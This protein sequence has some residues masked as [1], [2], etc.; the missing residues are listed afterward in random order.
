MF[1]KKSFVAALALLVV[2]ALLLIALDADANCSYWYS[3]MKYYYSSFLDAL[4]QYGWN[5]GLTQY[6]YSQY[7][8]YYNLWIN[9]CGGG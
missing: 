1:R 2:I 6:Y 5:H 4:G 9:N 7:Q 8:Y 3:A